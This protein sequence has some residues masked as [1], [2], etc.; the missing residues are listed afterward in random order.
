MDAYEAKNQELV[1]ENADLRTLL[2]SMQVSSNIF[3][4]YSALFVRYAKF[5]GHVSLF[6]YLKLICFVLL[7]EVTFL[8]EK[9]CILFVKGPVVHR[10]LKPR[11]VHLH[12]EHLAFLSLVH[13]YM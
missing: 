12:S 5:S 4:N 8:N 7:Q 3:R 1:T 9:C 2:R 13:I 6:I 10:D 11:F